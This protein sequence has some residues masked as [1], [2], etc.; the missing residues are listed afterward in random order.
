M[1]LLSWGKP[2]IEIAPYVNGALPA[3]PTWTAL[4]ESKEGSSNMNPTK[5]NKTEATGEGGELV[6]VRYSRNKYSFVTDLF[7]KKG[8]DKPIED[9]DGVVEDYYAIRLTPED[10]TNEGWLMEKTKVSVEES[11]T[12]ADGKYWKYTFDG[13]KPASGN[14]LKPYTKPVT[15]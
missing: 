14:I 9:V 13:L 6:D 12:A 2:L 8:D 5:G 1:S 15:P 3:T 7:V 10:D 4:P 11:W